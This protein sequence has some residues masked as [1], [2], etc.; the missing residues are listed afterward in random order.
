MGLSSKHRISVDL[1]PLKPLLLERARSGNITPS[2]L[3]RNALNEALG[4][5]GASA[6]EERSPGETSPESERVRLSLRMRRDEARVVLRA[7]K[8]AGLTPGAYVAGLAAG[9][10]ALQGGVS[11]ARHVDALIASNSTIATLG[12]DMRQM[13]SL[14]SLGASDA[15]LQYR[16]MLDTLASDMRPHLELAS[17]V[18]AELRPRATAAAQRPVSGRRRPA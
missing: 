6:I 4:P 18:L 2:Q 14:I 11:R 12:R 15:A 1:G 5:P 16:A 3:V 7:A 13:I 10:P 9:V 8:E 17:A